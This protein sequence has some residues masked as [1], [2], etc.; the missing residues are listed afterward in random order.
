MWFLNF[1]IIQRILTFKFSGYLFGRIL[2]KVMMDIDKVEYNITFYNS[3]L[4]G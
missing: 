3:G 2:I 4:F 1:K